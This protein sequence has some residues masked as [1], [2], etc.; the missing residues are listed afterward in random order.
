MGVS[1]GAGEFGELVGDLGAEVVDL[2]GG[3]AED[4]G[5]GSF[6]GGDGFLHV[7]AAVADDADGFGEG[8]GS[9]GDVGGVLAKGVAGG[10]GREDVLGGEGLRRKDA[11]GGGGDG[12]DGGLGVLGEAEVFFGAF[13]DEFG[14]G[15]AEGFVGFVED[16]AGGGVAIVEV[17]AHADGLGALAGEEEGYRLGW[18]LNGIRGSSV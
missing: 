11:V 7:A 4:G 17:A 6:S 1:V 12:E 15:E 10:V 14:E 16:G 3:E 5:H 9:G 2:V 8:D 18:G 13:E